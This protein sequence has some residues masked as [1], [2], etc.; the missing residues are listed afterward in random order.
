MDGGARGGEKWVKKEKEMNDDN[1]MKRISQGGKRGEK[2]GLHRGE[3]EA[4]ARLDGR[5]GP[6]GADLI[7]FLVVYKGF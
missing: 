7:V 1:A 6:R 3:W 4:T 5:W 2:G